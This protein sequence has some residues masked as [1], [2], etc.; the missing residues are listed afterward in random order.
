MVMVAGLPWRVRRWMVS[1]WGHACQLRLLR[2]LATCDTINTTNCC[3]PIS[4]GI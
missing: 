2:A 1:E 3:C 4:Q